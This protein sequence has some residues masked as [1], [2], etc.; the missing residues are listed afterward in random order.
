VKFDGKRIGWG[1]L[2]WAFDAN[3]KVFAKYRCCGA[4]G[5][6]E[7]IN[8]INSAEPGNVLAI[9]LNQKHTGHQLV[10]TFKLASLIQVHL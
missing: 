8:L 4:N 6:G 1:G 9:L 5:C 2:N 3:K 7:L 10:R